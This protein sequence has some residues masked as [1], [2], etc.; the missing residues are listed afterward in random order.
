MTPTSRNK[1]RRSA[2]IMLLLIPAILFCVCSSFGLVHHFYHNALAG[3]I[4]YYTAV[5][6]VVVILVE[7]LLI[8]FTK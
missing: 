4:F 5:F 1:M 2:R 6:F 8:I 7:L 3:D